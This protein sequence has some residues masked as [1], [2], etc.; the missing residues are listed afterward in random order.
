MSRNE[1]IDA[2]ISDDINSIHE[3]KGEYNDET[4]IDS[5]LRSGFEGYENFT[6][7]ELMQELEERDISYLFGNDDEN[8]DIELEQ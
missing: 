3:S 6:D 1:M 4:F 5:L 7:E 2:L 8:L